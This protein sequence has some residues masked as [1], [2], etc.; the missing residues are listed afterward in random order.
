MKNKSFNEKLKIMAVI[1]IGAVIIGVVLASLALLA[2]AI[3][4]NSGVMFYVFY[5]AKCLIYGGFFIMG[6]IFMF[7][8]GVLLDKLDQKK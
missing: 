6:G 8:F 5:L 2:I 7:A 1:L 3:H 4:Y